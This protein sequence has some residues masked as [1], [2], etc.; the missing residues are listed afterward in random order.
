MKDFK[1]VA[2]QIKDALELVVPSDQPQAICDK[3]NELTMLTGSAAALQANAKKALL[4]KELELL[5]SHQSEGLQAS[6]LMRLIQAESYEESAW[7]CYAERL[8]AG[9]AHS[10]DGLRSELSYLKEEIRNNLQA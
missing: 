1:V 5:K 8:S 3:I 10:M 9:I 6:V 2:Q 4:K 7:L